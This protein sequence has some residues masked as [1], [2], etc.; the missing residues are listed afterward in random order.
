MPD[1]KDYSLPIPLPLIGGGL[2]IFVVVVALGLS[3]YTVLSLL[4]RGSH[5]PFL[6][7]RDSDRRQIREERRR[8]GPEGS[9]GRDESDSSLPTR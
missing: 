5:S 1:T 3:R 9:W 2:R 4:E 6:G 7:E 8:P